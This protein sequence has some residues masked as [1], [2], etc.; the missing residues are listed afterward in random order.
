LKFH[1]RE[2]NLL[3]SASKDH[4]LRLWNIKTRICIAIF[5]GVDGHRDEVLST[6]FD[7]GLRYIVSS[8]MDHSLKVWRID[9]PEMTEAIAK[10]YSYDD[11]FCRPFETLKEH[12]AYYSTRD[13]HRN[14]VDSVK[15]FGNLILSKSCEN[16]IVCWKPGQI[17]DEKLKPNETK[18]TIFHT[19]DLPDCEIWYIRFDTDLMQHYI[20]GGNQNGKVYVWNVDCEDPELVK[21]TILTHFRSV[22]PVRQVA[23]SN[24]AKIL[25][26][27]CDDG[28]IFRWDASS[29]QPNQENGKN[30]DHEMKDL[31]SEK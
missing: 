3:L 16:E 1:P 17:D 4:S 23:F 15:W 12:F 29:A 20:A 6:D 31:S 9:S 22:T 28:S 25:I 27:V 7:L 21:P 11:A 19:F 2:F 10:S 30:G 26:S 14:Y 13:I 24:N 8:G 18:S 5:G